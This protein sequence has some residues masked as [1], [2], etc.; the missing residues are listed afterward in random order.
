MSGFGALDFMNKT[1]KQNRGL[2]KKVNVFDRIKPYSSALKNKS[3]KIDGTSTPQGLEQI[4]AQTLADNN[5]HSLIQILKLI[6]V[7][8]VIG[9]VLFALIGGVIIGKG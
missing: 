7:L 9:L 3:I 8:L 6:G 4:K 5:R 2:I 1:L